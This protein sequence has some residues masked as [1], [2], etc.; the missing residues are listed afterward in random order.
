M[1][2]NSKTFTLSYQ[3][4][5]NLAFD[6]KYNTSGL[7]TNS[8]NSLNQIKNLSQAMINANGNEQL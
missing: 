6:K 4:T 8:I 2:K 3:Q 1:A 5:I 7:V